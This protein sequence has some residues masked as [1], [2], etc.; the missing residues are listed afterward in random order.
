MER[1]ER[2]VVGRKSQKKG[3]GLRRLPARLIGRAVKRLQLRRSDWLISSGAPL[4]RGRAVWNSCKSDRGDVG[5]GFEVDRPSSVERGEKADCSR[6]SSKGPRRSSVKPSRAA[7]RVV[8][9][10]AYSGPAPSRSL[11]EPG[12]LHDGPCLSNWGRMGRQAM[13]QSHFGRLASTRMTSS[14]LTSEPSVSAKA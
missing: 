6:W 7:A 8:Q 1:T 10:W 2:K 13:Q 5:L 3:W 9:P 12:V 4:R 14:H 11:R